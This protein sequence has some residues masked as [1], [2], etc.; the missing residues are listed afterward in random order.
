[1]AWVEPR[2]RKGKLDPARTALFNQLLASGRPQHA[3]QPPQPAPQL[4][5]APSNVATPAPE[6]AAG[7]ARLRRAAAAAGSS[8]AASAMD[9]A[10]SGTERLERHEAAASAMHA[11][12]GTIRARDAAAAAAENYSPPAAAI[13]GAPLAAV[14][15]FDEEVRAAGEGAARDFAVLL[16]V[17]RRWAGLFGTAHVPRDAFDAGLLGAW[18]TSLRKAH[19]LRQLA[20]EKVQVRGPRATASK[21]KFHCCFCLVVPV[22]LMCSLGRMAR[23]HWL[24]SSAVWASADSPR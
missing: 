14:P 24:H 17:L 15:S 18:V 20:A 12:A 4:T 9:A 19:T 22:L 16:R 1:M 8:A 21:L 13:P 5:E 2:C 6:P 23:C 10:S 11:T 7:V 3:A